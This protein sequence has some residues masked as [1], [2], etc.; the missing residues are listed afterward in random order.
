MHRLLFAALALLLSSPA[1][2]LIIDASD[3]APYERPPKEDPGWA[4]V[5]QR[6]NIVRKKS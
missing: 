5:G 4:Y 3:D 6:A 1:A 2:A